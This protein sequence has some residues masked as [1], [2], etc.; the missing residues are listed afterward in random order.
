MILQGLT[1][2]ATRLMVK[3]EFAV[4]AGVSASH[5]AKSAAESGNFQIVNGQRCHW[6][7]KQR[8]WI[9]V[10]DNRHLAAL[11]CEHYTERLG[12]HATVTDAVEQRAGGLI[13]GRLAY[14]WSK[15]GIKPQVSRST[16]W[17]FA[18]GVFDTDQ[19]EVGLRPPERGD[20]ITHFLPYSI[21]LQEGELPRE[22]VN[23]IFSAL[24][25]SDAMTSYL[26]DTLSY[27]LFSPNNWQ[28]C[29]SWYG[30]GGAGKG[31]LT[32]IL[33]AL[34]GR[35][36]CYSMD[37]DALYQ[38][39]SEQLVPADGKQLLIA[40]EAHRGI[41]KEKLK[42]LTGQ[43]SIQVRALYGMPFE[44]T[45]GGHL[46]MVSNPPFPDSL[47][48][49]GMMRRLEPVQFSRAPSKPDLTLEPR[50]LGQL[51]LICGALFAR[52]QSGVARW[53]EWPTPIEVQRD[54]DYYLSN[55]N[56][57]A[58][59][60]VENVKKD[61]NGSLGM[62]DI[63][64]R[65]EAERGEVAG[66]ERERVRKAFQRAIRSD[67][68]VR[69]KD[70]RNWAASWAD[71]IPTQESVKHTQDSVDI[72]P[73]NTGDIDMECDFYPNAKSGRPTCKIKGWQAW[74]ERDKTELFRAGQLEKADLSAITPS[75]RGAS[76]R[77]SVAA[78]EFHNG[79]LCFDVDN[80]GSEEAQKAKRYV[81]EETDFVQVAWLSPSDEGIKFLVKLARTPVTAQEHKA[82]YMD[83]V[84]QLEEIGIECDASCSD[85]ARLCFLS[86]DELPVFNHDSILY[87]PRVGARAIDLN[88]PIHG[89]WREK[90][91]HNQLVRCAAHYAKTC[92]AEQWAQDV[93][94]ALRETFEREKGVTELTNP[95]SKEFFGAVG[96]AWEKYG[97]KK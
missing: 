11:C 54:L 88:F 69:L 60:V 8:Q 29:F 25:Q 37:A 50:L 68:G 32:R 7:A 3:D 17:G 36:R 75:V 44:F 77:S 97:R 43:D 39:R 63:M 45:F 70:S 87:K 81:V 22:F 46:L 42:A 90:N 6:E 40:Q 18:E 65:Y 21:K 89:P 26:L 28:K 52:W 49:T 23:V 56:S 67:L 5:I 12:M 55:E 76:H 19:P 61:E 64:R 72:A 93:V 4:P 53:N 24:E 91:R 35:G 13:A 9:P 33:I 74:Q 51:G 96:T 58:A 31:L 82:V 71:E 84:G 78:M 15:E 2:G 62:A 10:E 95:L 47:M 66:K 92:D 79:W 20:Y 14:Q 30:I 16:L 80:L 59:W 1:L 86:F 83:I 41:P 27:M 94:P 34:L 57:P 85:P 73:S 48:D 38:G